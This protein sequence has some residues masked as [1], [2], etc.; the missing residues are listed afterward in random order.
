MPAA[1]EDVVEEGSDGVKRDPGDGELR[2]ELVSP[3]EE[4]IGDEGCRGV[5]VGGEPVD[6]L[7]LEFGEG[8]DEGVVSGVAD[9]TNVFCSGGDFGVRRE[10]EDEGL[11]GVWMGG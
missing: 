6:Y 3:A 11:D 7:G 1:R 8:I 5:R 9:L 4:E 10:W 2:G